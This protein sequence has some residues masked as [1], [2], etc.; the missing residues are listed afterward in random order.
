[1]FEITEEILD[2]HIEKLLDIIENIKEKRI[3]LLVGANGTGKSLIRK[4]LNV[5]FIKQ[6]NANRNMVRHVSQQM[7]TELRS[8][9]GALACIAMDNPEDPT[10]MCSFDMIGK[11]TNYDM[12]EKDYYIVLDEAE[13]GMSE[14]SVLGLCEHLK[15]VLPEWLENSLG[16]L[17]ITHSSLLAEYIHSNFDCDFYNIG[18]NSYSQDFD[19]WKTREI[20]P[21][22]FNWLKD[23]S[24][25]LFRRV[26]D[27]SKKLKKG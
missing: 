19:A 1:M 9:M 6:Y 15:G 18:Y 4:Q 2:S 22:D 26:N 14:E 21:T 7:R 27:R 8:D 23:W 24:L 3:T 5:R 12:K 10:S 13:I 11:V 17:I 25:A 20:K 16:I